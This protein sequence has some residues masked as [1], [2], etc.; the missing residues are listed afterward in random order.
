MALYVSEN[1]TTGIV[2]APGGNDGGGKA[3]A[4]GVRGGDGGRSTRNE[5]LSVLMRVA[6]G[7]SG[8]GGEGG[9]GE[10]GGGDGGGGL[11]GG[12]LGGGGEGGGGDGGLSELSRGNARDDERLSIIEPRSAD[13]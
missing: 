1:V 8:G 5:K 3:G 7:S 4:G 10:G 13:P 2:L 6:P 11:G 12:G 9:G